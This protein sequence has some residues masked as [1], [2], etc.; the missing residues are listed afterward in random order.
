MWVWGIKP[1][2]ELFAESNTEN[3]QIPSPNISYWLEIDDK[4]TYWLIKHLTGQ[5]V[6]VFIDIGESLSV[7]MN[8]NR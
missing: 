3:F 2:Y 1:W 4:P 8:V 5:N 7:H 6:V